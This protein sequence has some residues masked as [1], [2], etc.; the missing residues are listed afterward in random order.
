MCS[1]AST[2][3]TSPTS[4]DA[5]WIT[6]NM[7]NANR[8]SLRILTALLLLL[9]VVGLVG[10]FI[11]DISGH[12]PLPAFGFHAGFILLQL[13][14]VAGALTLVTIVLADDPI[15]RWRYLPPLIHPPAVLH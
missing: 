6:C 15:H 1:I 9:V 12:E 10:H 8:H 2:P 11:V 5:D 13:T 3:I 4:A 7:A 14:V